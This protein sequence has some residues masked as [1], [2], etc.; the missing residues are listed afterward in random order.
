M[1]KKKINKKNLNLKLKS[2]I[3]RFNK[4][5]GIIYNK[6]NIENIFFILKKRININNNIIIFKKLNFRNNI[7]SKIKLLKNDN[8]I[9]N[10]NSFF[11]IENL[12]K[13]KNNIIFVIINNK[14][15]L[16]N[17]IINFYIY[18]KYKLILEF[19]KKKK[20]FFLKNFFSIYYKNYNKY[21][22]F[23]KILNKLNA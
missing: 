9:I 14:I 16:N 23:F 15:Y 13:L 4:I 5:L 2:L 3:I 20:F 6:Q 22:I 21:N 17:N 11:F 12:K 7:I 18:N 8:I 19:I 1:L 10:I